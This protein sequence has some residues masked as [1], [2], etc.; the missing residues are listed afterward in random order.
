MDGIYFPGMGIGFSNVP[1]GF[2][3]FGYEIKFY[4][5]IITV[6][7]LLA[8]MIACR[9]AKKSGQ[10][11]DDYIDYLLVMIVPV[12]LGA[13]IYYVLFNLKEY[14][15]P[16]KSLGQ[17]LLDMINIRNGG[18]A[19]YGGLIAGVLV[20]VIYTKKKKIYLP[21]FADTIAMGVF[22]G[23]ILGRWGNFFNR[24]A[25]GAYTKA[26][27]RM[28]IPVSY[29]EQHG[30]YQYLVNSGIISEKM[31][32]NPEVVNG[33]ACITVTPTFLF[34]GLWNL[35][36]LIF[37][38]CYRKKKK[39]DGELAL[40]YVAGY[41]IGRFLVE[42]LRTDSLMIGPFKISQLVGLA[43][44]IVAFAALLYNYI[45]IKKGKEPKC[46]RVA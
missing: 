35:M 24:E 3:I 26:F 34:E 17:T 40:F 22:V 25:F 10:N 31:I 43:C 21:L 44:F 11:P 23:Q 14:V 5:L 13:R 28:A 38:F 46:H 18:L 12:I 32:Q 20:A 33:M 30:Y 42:A 2:T 7:F 8:L 15:A 37:I 4:G 9:D 45:S 41:G 16:G 1:S 19:I 36:L 27:Y 39:F 29:Y 6:G